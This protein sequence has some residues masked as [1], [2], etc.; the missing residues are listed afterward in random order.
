MDFRKLVLLH[1][2]DM[3]G[4]F[5]AE[6][7]HDKMVGGLSLLSGYINS[8]RTKSPNTVFVVSGDMLQGSILDTEYRGISTIDLMNLLKPDVVTLGNHEMDYGLSHL[9]FLERCAKFPV[10]NA[11]LM[12]KPTGTRLFKSHHI[13]ELNGIRILFIGIITEDILHL[14]PSDPI[15]STFVNVQEAA[16]EVEKICNNYHSIDIDLT[17][18]LTHVGYENDIELAKLLSPDLG[19]DIIIGGHSHTF[20]DKPTKV[21]NILIAQAGVGTD[22]IGRFDLV[23]NMDTN[24]IHEYEWNLVPITD[25]TCQQDK[26]L[27]HLLLNYTEQI[28]NKYDKILCRMKS[29]LKHPNRYEE[30]QAGNMFADILKSSTG[31]DLFILGSGSLRKENLPEIVT[32]KELKEFYPYDDKIYAL[33]IT[34]SDL[35]EMITGFWDLYYRQLTHEFYQY[36][37][38]FQVVFDF[39]TGDVLDIFLNGNP[40][41]ADKVYTI[42]LQNFH[43]L[44]MEKNFGIS[45]E[46]VS[47]IREPKCVCTSAIQVFEEFF[48]NNNDLGGNVVGRILQL[49]HNLQES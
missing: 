23:I 10:I 38:G 25:E 34:G 6:K 45:I 37:E 18:L 5:F 9:L 13:M 20:L 36:S 33:K 26:L 1:S 12:I 3:H 29:S 14:T 49:N 47:K 39:S 8:V 28:E 4:D 27:K 17:V 35:K 24:S 42:G 40:I 41:V 2:N 19:V 16:L 7:Q 30:T 22:F 21:N 48:S 15:L 43:F 32:L 44:N 46:R 11:N 31:V